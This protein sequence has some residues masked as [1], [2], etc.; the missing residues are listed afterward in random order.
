MTKLDG[1]RALNAS[2]QCVKSHTQDYLLFHLF[3]VVSGGNG[4]TSISSD[5]GLLYSVRRL[6]AGGAPSKMPKPKLFLVL[7]GYAWNV[8]RS[9]NKIYVTDKSNSKSL[10][11][12]YSWMGDHNE[13]QRRAKR[14]RTRCTVIYVTKVKVNVC[15]CKR[16]RKQ[17]N[18]I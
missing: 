6:V 11:K 2:S 9:A 10:W 18:M 15:E 7:F 1:E 5:S 4:T 12:Y 14:Y 17:K 8:R 3:G 16:E 13:N